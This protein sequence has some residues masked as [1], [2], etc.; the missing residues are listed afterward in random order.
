MIPPQV[1][2]E[3]QP[4]VREEP[5]SEA[6]WDYADLGLFLFLSFVSMVAALL[7]LRFIPVLHSLKDAYKLLAGQGIWY[8]FVMGSLAAIFN[9][10]YGEPFWKSL[11]WRTPGIG[12]ALASLAAGPLVAIGL[13]LLG[14]ALRTPQMPLPFENML[15]TTALIA[16]FGLLV[17]FIG[18][19]CEELAFRGFILPLLARSFG[20]VAGIV[21]TGLLFGLLHG[22]EYPDWRPIVLVAV[23]GMIFGWR[24][25]QTGSTV[26]S[27]LMHAGFNLT[28]FAALLAAKHA[29]LR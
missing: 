22:F 27:T 6:F 17:V 9:I 5:R 13:G 3:P 15:N 10:R 20:S 21:V 25:Y 26:N 23:A 8:V 14:A 19:L 28:Q 16:L 18:P 12:S 29:H 2:F 24:R 4:V 7:L 1:P 11:G